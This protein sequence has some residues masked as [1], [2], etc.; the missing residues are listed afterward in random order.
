L[1]RHLPHLSCYQYR[2]LKICHK[3]DLALASIC[4]W[5][6]VFWVMTPCI[7]LGGYWFISVYLVCSDFASAPYKQVNQRDS[8]A[9]THWTNNILCSSLHLCYTHTVPTF[10]EWGSTGNN[11]HTA[12]HS[13]L[14]STQSPFFKMSR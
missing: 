10:E 4:F 9:G 2:K 14:P 13:N 6:V 8:K 12:C 5:T 3:W 7:L 11:K 1:V